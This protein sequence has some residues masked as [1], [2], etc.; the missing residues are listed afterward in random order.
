MVK[1]EDKTRLDALLVE[2][3]LAPSRQKAQ[4]LIMAGKVR[5][6][7]QIVSKA[8]K[9]V[10]V[11]SSIEV[12]E[13]LPYVSRGGV[14]LAG[15][16]DAFSID[17]SGRAILDIGSSTGGFTDC[18]LKRGAARVYAID[19]GK[20]LIDVNLRHD[21]RVA[22]LEGRNIRHL[23]PEEVGGKAD[24][25][26][27][28]VSF[29]SLRLVLPKVKELLKEAGLALCLVKPQF[30]VGKGEVGK[31]GIVKD[32]EKQRAVV[33][34]IM[35]FAADTGFKT[36]G[37]IESPITGRKGNR[38]FWLYLSLPR[39]VPTLERGNDKLERGNDNGGRVCSR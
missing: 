19:V 24:M 36:V 35:V 9:A 4:A 32:P 38:E 10:S 11:L 21:P 6:D 20:G 12:K 25:A 8:G 37:Q 22:L 17:V 34:R 5:A 15:A 29:I 28:D 14:K 23:M 39:S 13:G 18:L 16:L 26:V 27:I 1:K 7:G 31:G 30:E 3:G 33:E 2:R